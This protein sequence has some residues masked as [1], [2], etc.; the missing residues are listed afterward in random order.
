MSDFEWLGWESDPHPSS[1]EGAAPPL[2]YPAMKL[3]LTCITPPSAPPLNL[4]G[5]IW[6]NVRVLLKHAG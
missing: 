6:Y 5:E 1:Y 3:I 4:R 2:S